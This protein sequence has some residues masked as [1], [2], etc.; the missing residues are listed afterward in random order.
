MSRYLIN[1]GTE[2]LDAT[3]LEE[4][5]QQTMPGDPIVAAAR[6]VLEE[7]YNE[8]SQK[9]DNGSSWYRGGMLGADVSNKQTLTE[10]RELREQEARY[11]AQGF[12]K[13]F[14][15]GMG[16]RWLMPTEDER[17]KLDE[18]KR[19]QTQRQTQRRLDQRLLAENTAFD[20]YEEDPLVTT[21]QEIQQA[22]NRA[23]FRNMLEELGYSADENRATLKP[24]ASSATEADVTNKPYGDGREELDVTAVENKAKLAAAERAARKVNI[25]GGFQNQGQN[26]DAYRMDTTF[27]SAAALNDWLKQFLADAHTSVAPPDDRGN[28]IDAPRLAVPGEM[29][30]AI[31]Q[32]VS[33]NKADE[34]NRAAFQRGRTSAAAGSERRGQQA[35]DALNGNGD[36]GSDDFSM[37]NP[38]PGRKGIG[39]QNQAT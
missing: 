18:E 36:Y 23:A 30:A 31:H 37:D 38:R 25:G 29:T 17:R 20:G 24:H 39:F 4:G 16:H 1:Y 10:S 6:R 15:P 3:T 33:D 12:V 2:S 26:A 11:E 5:D 35:R 28:A 34:L 32:A 21:L 19:Q 22:K 7:N 8:A 9:T 14:I 13:K 27:K